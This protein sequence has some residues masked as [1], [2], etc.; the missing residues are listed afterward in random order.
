MIRTYV[1]SGVLI[2]AA[3]GNTAAA[4][5][6]LPFLVDPSREYVTSDFVRI[7]VLPK[8]VYHRNTAEVA[9]YEGFLGLS[10]VC[11]PPSAAVLTLAMEEACRTGISGIDALHIASAVLCGAKEFITLR[12]GRAA[13]SPYHARASPIDIPC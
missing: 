7:E 9:F 1:D 2:Y 13:N 5:L 4:A 12:K 6:A 3:K 11:V 10:I 8:A